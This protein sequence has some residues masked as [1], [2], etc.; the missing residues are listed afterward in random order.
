MSAKVKRRELITLIGGAAAAWPLAAR[1]Q[2][3]RKL[4]TI[5]LL[6]A[7]SPASHSRW[8]AALVKRLNELGWIEGRTITIEYRWAEGRNERYAEIAE[9]FI[10][11][12]VDVIVTQGAAVAAAKQSTST[13]PIVF[14]V[15]ADPLGSGLVESLARPGGNVTGLSLQFTDLAGKRLE[16]LR[17]AVS[18]LARMAIMANGGYRAAVLPPAG[19]AS[20]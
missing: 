3:A 12:K 17:E 9:E 19:S 16:L 1:G 4:P 14:T 15:A 8:V 7:G 10:R 5:G 2:Q 6:T 18:G 13:I 11:L 20:K